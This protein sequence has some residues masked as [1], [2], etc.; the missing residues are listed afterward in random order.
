[1]PLW[2]GSKTPLVRTSDLDQ[3]PLTQLPFAVGLEKPQVRGDER[4]EEH[5]ADRQYGQYHQGRRGPARAPLSGKLCPGV[6]AK[7]ETFP[8]GPGSTSALVEPQAAC[9]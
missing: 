4:S 2:H 8:P 9:A 1:M 7:L 6:G 5:D 3:D